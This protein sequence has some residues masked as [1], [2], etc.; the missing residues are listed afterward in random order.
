MRSRDR[1]K[2]CGVGGSSLIKLTDTILVGDGAIHTTISKAEAADGKVGYLGR[3]SRRHITM[4]LLETAP[5]PQ[6]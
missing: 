6:A 5:D 2:R 1:L 3:I 4:R